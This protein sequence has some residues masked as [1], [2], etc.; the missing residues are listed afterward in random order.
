MPPKRYH[1]L[2]VTHP[3]RL[4]R[5]PKLLVLISSAGCA[6]QTP[7]S[8]PPPAP[9]PIIIPQQP[10]APAPF[11]TQSGLA[12]FYGKAHDGKTTANGQIFDSQAL[13]AA[14]RTLAFG[15][16][17]RV[18]NLENGREVTVK[19]TD[20]GPF[21]RGRIIDISLAAAQ[22]LGFQDKGVARVRLE[23]F[24]SNAPSS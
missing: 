6:S 5:L 10:S 17:V 7:P 24:G 18:T 1:H 8:A 9:P 15:T 23:A 3:M 2:C 4:S 19:I 13:T 11:F 14:H 21:V 22:A 12:S 16:E 20:R